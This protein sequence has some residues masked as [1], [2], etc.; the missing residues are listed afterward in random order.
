M[1]EQAWEMEQ[2]G[3]KGANWVAGQYAWALHVIT[4]IHSIF[5]F[6]LTPNYFLLGFA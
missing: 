6:N 5:L 4:S 3:T 2:R 1:E